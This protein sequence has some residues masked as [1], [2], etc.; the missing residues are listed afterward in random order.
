M[1][2]GAL[3]ARIDSQHSLLM[4]QTLSQ[5]ECTSDYMGNNAGVIRLHH[6]GISSR[7]GALKKHKSNGQMSGFGKPQNQCVSSILPFSV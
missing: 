6:E 1:C 5:G 2:M 4:I 7:S 3:D